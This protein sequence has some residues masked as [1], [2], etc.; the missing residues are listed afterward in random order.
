MIERDEARFMHGL[1]LRGDIH[2]ACGIITDKDDRDPGCDSMRVLEP[3]RLGRNHCGQASR[4]SLAVDDARVH[5]FAACASRAERALS[6]PSTSTVFMR[7]DVPDA[8]RI[9]DFLT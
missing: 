5:C 3:C 6:S 4:V 7:D 9:S 1:A 8:I 2:G